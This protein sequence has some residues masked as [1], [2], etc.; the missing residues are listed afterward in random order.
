MQSII[1]SGIAIIV[2]IQS[3]GAWL[4]VPMEFFSNLGTEDFFFIV[5]PLIYWSINSALGIRVGFIL[6]A[7]STL[8]YIGKLL[9]A[10]PRPY[11]V[12]SQV[13]GLWPEI[14]F[15][16]P[17]GHAQNA[18]SVW[19]IIAIHFKKTW[20]RVAAGL[21]IFL[22]GFS[23]LYL[24]SHFLHDVLIG[25]IFGG[26]LLFAFAKLDAPVT[27][28]L[29]KKTMWQQ[30]ATGFIL[31]LILVLFGFLA[32]TLRED[33]QLPEL[34]M[35]NAL[36]ASTEVPVPVDLNGIFTSAGTFFGL[37][38]GAAWVMQNGG[39]QA[40]GPVWKRALRYI[41]GLIGVLIFWM[42]LGE[43][44]PRGDGVMIYT[45]R[46]I[47]YALVGWWVAGGAPWVFAR[48]NLSEYL[49]RSI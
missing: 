27:A 5:L 45:L 11:W 9:F 3:M 14:T 10:G 32:V 7:S 22:I 15:G 1:E 24:G 23:R 4:V 16:A 36:L 41:I 31:S 34:W 13:K 49:K 39:Y 26:L 35:T 43:I 18:M 44:F 48:L 29:A 37:A 6:V 2:A 21:L 19:G 38:V 28:W 8:N 12:S 46:Y 40:E 17:S 42:G 33:F 20:V 30:I 25:W 47:R